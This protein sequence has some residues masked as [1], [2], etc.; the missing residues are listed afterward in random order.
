LAFV[1]LLS[2]AAVFAADADLAI[3]KSGPPTI[4]AG[5]DLLYDI[6]VH[7]A[8]PDPATHVLV[9]DVFSLPP[10]GEGEA[11]A[12]TCTDGV[13]NDGDEN[14]DQGDNECE[15]L[16][17]IGATA[18]CALG[19]STPTEGWVVCD[20]G[21]LA[22]DEWRNFTVK[23]RVSPG[24]YAKKEFFV[25]N[26]ATVTAV[27][28]DPDASDNTELVDTIVEEVSDLRIS[29]FVEPSETVR[30]GDTFW[31]TIWVDNYGPSAARNVTII[32]TLLNSGDVTVQ[33]C[34]FS[35]SQGGGAIEQ[36]T[37][38]TG[39]LVQTQFGS[40]IGTFKTNYLE[41]LTASTEGRLRGSFRLVAYTDIDV[42]NTTRVGSDTPDP[43][44]SNNMADVNID[45]VP[46]ADLRLSA[47]FGGEVQ[48]D[49]EY[50]LSIDAN[51]ALP[52][53]PELPNYNYG[54]WHVTAGRRIA[55]NGTTTNE[56]PSPANN[57][58]IE[59][60]LPAGANVLPTTLNSN[61]EGDTAEGRCYTEPAGEPRTTVICQ[62]D[63]LE[64]DAKAKAEFQVLI[65]PNVPD[66]TS[67]SIDALTRADEFDPGLMDNAV[68]LQFSVNNW[69]DLGLTKFAI[70]AP[71]AGT[72]MH[73]ELQIENSG[74]SVS[75]DLTLRDFLPQGMT[76]VSAFI[77]YEAPYAPTT[78]LPC[79]LTVGSNVLFCP[80]GDLPPTGSMPVMVF[81]NVLTNS[82]V[83]KDT[84]LTNTADVNLKDTPDPWPYDNVSQAP[85]TSLTRADLQLTKTA[86]ADIYAPSARMT[87]ILTVKNKG[88]SA[89]QDVVVTDSLPPV[90]TATYV[91]DSGGCQLAGT[92][93]TCAV[94][95][96][97]NGESKSINVYMLPKGKKGSVTN[98]ATVSSITTDLIESNN[99]SSKTVLI[100][101]GRK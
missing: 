101:G 95:T 24:Y 68:S 39:P 90:T 61:P 2:P 8:G 91:S 47:T 48:V 31:Y 98:S 64:V 97:E 7:N 69:A 66:G 3:Y 16:I 100:K 14:I 32:D 28:T 94:G 63:T 59:F 86:T 20:L 42:T 21:D 45:V 29:K 50:G 80:L 46:V 35:V 73:Y 19:G 84:A 58:M 40:D 85:L 62:Y 5:T 38:T 87:F 15:G 67:L 82:D 6:S 99:T 33:S 55:F 65:D 43:D 52:A 51:V 18:T 25:L 49:G 96:L 37:C 10:I 30:A 54:G 44:A 22:V 78:P 76:F 11:G 79:G 1:L 23:F 75:H 34:A 36:F 88:P 27:E 9:T 57:V 12:A 93:L 89:A 71:I 81:I 83:P 72:Q 41:P 60:K 56:G 53:M 26:M 70:G 74:P 13:D 92:T 17:Y 4:V 77:D